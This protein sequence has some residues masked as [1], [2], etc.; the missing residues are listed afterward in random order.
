M[1]NWCFNTV[2][3][4]HEDV[5]K[6]D[7]LSTVLSKSEES[8]ESDVFNFLRPRPADQ[9]DNWYDWNVSNWGTKWDICPTVFERDEDNRVRVDFETAWGPP[10]ALYDFLTAEG[11]RV[12]AYYE[13]SGCGFCGKYEYGQD[14]CYEYTLDSWESIDAI[15]QDIAEFAG[16]HSAYEHYQEELKAEEGEENV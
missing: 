8:G 4:T 1:P 3:L 12:E 6:V 7:A 9:E 11:W 16:L 2:T 15:P 5:S 10:I 13:E 14:D